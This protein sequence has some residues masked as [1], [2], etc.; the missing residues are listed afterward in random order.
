[1]TGTIKFS[2]L[3]DIGCVRTNNE[4]MVYAA[5]HLVRD[6]ETGGSA[7][8]TAAQAAAWA[9]ADGMGGYEGGEVASEI[10]CRSFASFMKTFAPCNDNEG[11]CALKNWAVETNSLVLSTADLRPELSEMGTTFV[12]LVFAASGA[13]IINIGDSRCYRLRSGV[14][15]QITTDHSERQLTGDTSVPSNLIYNFMG[16]SPDNFISDVA[17]LTVLP[18]D[19]YLL[20]SDGLSDL[21][22]D[23]T[24]EELAHD[25]AT[26]VA[27]AKDRGGR[28][29]ISII[30][31]EI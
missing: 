28:D 12:A 21:V 30:K 23:D 4:D 7:E 8:V 2:A 3:C 26:L 10:V 14:L 31:V 15:K 24:M 17:A 1:M 25:P 20:C 18:G 11:I 5:G 16:N 19:V 13:Y 27:A 9:V 6:G 22:D 29:N